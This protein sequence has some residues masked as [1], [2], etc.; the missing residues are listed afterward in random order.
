MTTLLLLHLLAAVLAPLLVRWWGRR[1]FLVL[2]LVPAA[3]FGGVLAQLA[4]VTGG[5]EVRQTTP[6]GPAPDL[7]ISLRLHALSLTFALLVTG[8]G[9]PLLGFLPRVLQA[10]GR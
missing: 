3:A 5:G 10:R 6:W 8:V 4:A 2:A 9:A 7:Q 1:A